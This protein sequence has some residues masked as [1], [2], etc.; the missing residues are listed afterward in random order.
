MKENDGAVFR[1]GPW[2]TGSSADSELVPIF[3]AEFLGHGLSV[4]LFKKKK[5]EKKGGGEEKKAKE[6]K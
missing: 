6:I 4:C 1:L 2:R 3:N 5:K